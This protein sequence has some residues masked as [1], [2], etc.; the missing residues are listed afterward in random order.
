MRVITNS[1]KQIRINILES[2]FQRGYFTN[3]DNLFI[4]L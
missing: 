3:V 1:N 2:Y 4:S